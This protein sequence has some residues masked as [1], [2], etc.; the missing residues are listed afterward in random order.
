M[1]ATLAS[2]DIHEQVVTIFLR[3]ALEEDAVLA[4]PVEIPLYQFV[5]LGLASNPF[6]AHITL[7][8]DI[9]L[10]ETLDLRDPRGNQRIG[11]EH[12]MLTGRWPLDGTSHYRISLKGW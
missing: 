12:L 2:M 11:G 8:K 6:R 4:T 3:D 5:A 7:R 1:A 10:Q 9:F